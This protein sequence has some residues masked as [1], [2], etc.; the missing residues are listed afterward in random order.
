MSSVLLTRFCGR[1]DVTQ[2]PARQ[3]AVDVACKLK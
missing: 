3:Q 2:N 1:A